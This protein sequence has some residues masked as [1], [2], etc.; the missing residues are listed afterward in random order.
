VIF[1]KANVLIVGRGLA[2]STLAYFLAEEGISVDIIDREL[3]QT[4]SKIAAGVIKPVTGRRIVKTWNAD[5]LIPFAVNFYNNIQTNVESSFF[6]KTKLLQV[7]SSVSDK[8]NWIARSVD[9]EVKEYFSNIVNPSESGKFLKSPYGGVYLNSCYRLETVLFLKEIM[10]LNN[11]YVNT[12]K[13]DFT[14]KNLKIEGNYV[15]YKNIKYRKIIF[16]E[17]FEAVKNQFFKDVPFAPLKGEILKIK[18][19][20]E[21]EDKIISSGIYIVPVGNKTAIA[22]ATYDWND[23]S[24]GTTADGKQKIVDK[25]KQIL[26]LP[27]Q[28]I[29]HKA[30]HRP[31]VQD[32]RPVIGLHNNFPSVGIFNGLG[33]KGVLL[34]PYYAEQLAAHIGRGHKIENEVNV[35]RFEA[36]TTNRDT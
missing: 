11:Q 4:S 33:T 34:A 24:S 22:G 10:V 5:T 25:L 29:S 35:R 1:E 26:T 15:S 19:S 27:Y 17:G 9:S 21:I 3:D 30:A 31:T 18:F 20:D 6:R 16:C 28:I 14:F 8:N 2:G 32:R 12:I 36:L 13:E 7:F 23:L